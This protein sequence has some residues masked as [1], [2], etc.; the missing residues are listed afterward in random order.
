MNMT[1]VP[2]S[3]KVEWYRCRVECGCGHPYHSLV[4]EHYA[5]DNVTT[6]NFSIGGNSFKER[7]RAAWKVLH[8]DFDYHD[9][10]I[11]DINIEQ[12]SAA[13]DNVKRLREEASL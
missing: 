6:L 1:R 9:I 7:L 8:G 12:L 4:V 11:N 3:L 5:E 10:I 13:I 2:V